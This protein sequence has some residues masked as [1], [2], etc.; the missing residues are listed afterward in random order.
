MKIVVIEDHTIVREM[1]M[2]ACTEAA[3]DGETRGAASGAAGV[4][5][6]DESKPHVAF[7]DVELPDGDGLDFADEIHRV[8]P[9]TKIIALTS[10]TEEFTIHRALRGH[11][12]GF[13][14]KNEQPLEVLKEAISTVMADRV[15]FSPAVHRVQKAM[16]KN[17]ADFSKVL[18][19][20]EIEL[21]KLFGAGLSNEEVATRARLTPGTAKLHRNRIMM[22]L[23]LHSTPEL[24]RY[25]MA[26]GFSFARTPPIPQD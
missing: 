17:P 12:S 1:L 14:D 19:D 23:D 16:Q 5:L 10:H 7:V 22:K 4:A 26:K 15:Y 13:V 8:S 9:A 24:M 2:L 25:A 11:I 18:S 20:R 21:L 3:G 6:C